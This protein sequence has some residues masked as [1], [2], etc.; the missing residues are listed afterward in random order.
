MQ[1][2]CTKC[3]SKLD[4]ATGKCPVCDRELTKKEIRKQKKEEK[5]EAKRTAKKEKWKKLSFKQK[6]KKICLRFV[7]IILV[8]LLLFGSGT[9]TLVYFEIVDIPA[10]SRIF[11]LMGVSKKETEA[12]G[13]NNELAYSGDDKQKELEALDKEIE[14]AIADLENKPIDADSYFRNNS[15]IVSE[16]RV[17]DSNNVSTEMEVYNNFA[18]RGFQVSCIET[19]YSMDGT[20]YSTKFISNTSQEKHPIYQMEYVAEN[21]SVWTILEINGTVM[22]YPV[23][24]NMQ[25]SSNVQ[26]IISEKDTVMSYDSRTGKFYETIPKESEL[27]VKKAS[28]IDVETIEN[29][30]DGEID[31]L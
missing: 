12:A 10:I 26:V 22:A 2:F 15:S 20:Y 28:R 1:K 23:S 18:G 19:E 7:L 3:G 25:S 24:Y 4:E 6:V 16:I 31:K 29:L 21:G 13:T 30:T 9:A 14:K 8:L 5:K 17:N 27:I 11:D